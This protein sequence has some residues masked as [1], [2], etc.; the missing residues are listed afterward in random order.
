MGPMS[1]V[2]DAVDHVGDAQGELPSARDAMVV[3]SHP[4]A[5]E[6]GLKVLREGG[7]AVDAAVAAAAVL[8]VV[9]PMSTGLGGDCFALVFQASDKSLHGINGSGAAPMAASIDALKALGHDCVPERGALSVTVPGAPHAWSQLLNRFGARSWAQALAPAIEVAEAGFDVT[10][11]VARDWAKAVSV[12]KAGAHTEPFLVNDAAPSAGDHVTFPD[13]AKTLRRLAEHGVSDFYSGEIARRIADT[14]E[15]LGG[16]LTIADLEAHVSTW[17]EPL[18]G[19]YRGHDVVQLPPNG[20]GLV[21]LEALGLLDE[22]SLADMGDAERTHYL[23]E[24]VKLA[25]GDVSAEL[26]DPAVSADLAARLLDFDYL[27]ERREALSETAQPGCIAPA[28]SNTVQVVVVDAQ[29]NACSLSNS[30]YEHF[31]SGV[32]VPETGIVLQNR[33]ALFSTQKGHPNALGPGR[34][35]YHTIIPAM[36]F[37]EASPWL[38]F[39]VVGGFQ[40]PQAQVQIISALIDRECS[41]ED[42]VAAPRFRFVDGL[43][44]QLEDGF[45]EADALSAR[46]HDVAKGAVFGGFGGAQAILVD[47]ESGALTGASDPRKDGSVGRLAIS[48]G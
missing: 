43:K 29:G 2:T 12:L 13:M 9:D 1:D 38:I 23:I 5:V 17:V 30:L 7:N 15:A 42:A 44:L 40:Q 32:V 10:E 47:R 20:Q 18:I 35:S 41:L 36:V 37:R 48:S 24:A 3:T 25:F 33:G 21:V 16:W 19:T 11:V 4:L 26:G 46:G 31:G 45:P 28:S 6:A 39:G 22:L 14:C 8:G 27:D 34:R